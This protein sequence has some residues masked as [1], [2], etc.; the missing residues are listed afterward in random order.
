MNKEQRVHFWVDAVSIGCA[1]ILA[2]TYMFFFAGCT[3]IEK[4]LLKA[5]PYNCIDDG[6]QLQCAS[7]GLEV[8]Y[9]KITPRLPT[10][11]L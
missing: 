8:K 1:V 9:E 10:G 7:E 5:E 2:I 6:T 3:S 11:E 4:K